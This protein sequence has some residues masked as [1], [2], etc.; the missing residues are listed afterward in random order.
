[1]S[2]STPTKAAR[3]RP[4]TNGINMCH[5][6]WML[7]YGDE[8]HGRG[9]RQPGA[10]LLRERTFQP[11]PDSD[12]ELRPFRDGEFAY[13]H[14]PTGQPIATEF[15]IPAI[16]PDAFILAAINVEERHKTEEHSSG[17]VSAYALRFDRLEERLIPILREAGVGVFD[18]IGVLSLVNQLT[19]PTTARPVECQQIT[20][21]V[22]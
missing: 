21:Q 13:F 6:A 17:Q 7:I 12:F 22:S 11:G 2:T 1:M 5:V 4:L 9:D 18:E 16:M 15:W 19:D 10:N 20:S 8:S 3:D 14:K